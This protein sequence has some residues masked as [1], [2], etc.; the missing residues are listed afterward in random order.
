MAVGVGTKT[1]SIFGPVD[2]KIYGPYPGDSDHVVV[3]KKNLPCRPCYRKF[4][5]SICER[6]ECLDTITPEDVL[7]AVD[8]VL[9]K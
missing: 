2:E 9:A 3:S 1:V 4:K 5:Y 8:K 7:D 6:R